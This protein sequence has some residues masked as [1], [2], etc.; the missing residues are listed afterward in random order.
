M[1]QFLFFSLAK[2]QRIYFQRL[3]DETELQGKVVA[4][5][6]MPWPHPWQWARVAG[7]IDWAH[8]V[9]EKCQERRV[10]RKYQGSL[11]RLLLRLEL[12]FM[13]LRAEA[14]LSRE[15][16]ANLVMWNG[17]HRYCQLLRAL[18]PEGCGTFFVENGLLPDTTTLDPR[19]V[20][21]FN[22]VPRDAAFYRAYAERQQGTDLQQAVTLIPR[23]PRVEGRVAIALPERFVFIPFQDDRDTQVRLF[24]PWIGNMRELFALGERVAAETGWTVVFKEHPSSRE[25]YPE[26]HQRTH[27]RLL[28]ANGNPTQELI[29]ASEFVITI[30]STV[31]LESLLLG[32]PLLTLGQAFFNVEGVVMHADS[33]GEMVRIV[34]AYPQWPVDE[35][36][37]RSFLHYLR[38]EYCVPGR[39]Q[40]SSADHLM[41]VARRMGA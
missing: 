41:E 24:S 30:N 8:L 38:H 37:R 18:L 40:D 29:E 6:N 11:Y 1:T 36:L 22:S 33:A 34:K 39:W 21:Y 2:H 3:L 9:E 23:K 26:L 10:K 15:R 27:E 13:A 35:A 4:P 32:K 12:A 25:S 7:R 17:S 5:R 28:F 20:N 14:L 16:P 19:G 31:G